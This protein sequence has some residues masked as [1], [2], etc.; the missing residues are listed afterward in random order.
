MKFTFLAAE[1]K[2]VGCHGLRV[3]GSVPTFTA[4]VKAK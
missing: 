3:Q 1:V 4:V 2:E